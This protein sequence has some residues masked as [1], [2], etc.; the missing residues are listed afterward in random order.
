M[1]EKHSG[2]A[3]FLCRV[4]IAAIHTSEQILRW[5]SSAFFDPTASPRRLKAAEGVKPTQPD[6]W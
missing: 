6:G 2:E 5:E 3:C 1:R 4:F